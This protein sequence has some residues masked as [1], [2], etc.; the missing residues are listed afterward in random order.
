MKVRLIRRD[1]RR[2]VRVT[3]GRWTKARMR[4]RIVLRDRRRHTVR[5][6]TDYR[7]HGP[8]DD[9]EDP[10]AGPR[11]LG[12][13]IGAVAAPIIAPMGEAVMP[14]GPPVS[15]GAPAAT[16]RARCCCAGSTRLSS[17]RTCLTSES[18][19]LLDAAGRD[20]LFRFGSG[21][22]PGLVLVALSVVEQ[23]YRAVMAVLDGARVS[24]VAAEVGRVAPVAAFVGGALS[25]GRAGRAGG[26]VE[27][28]AVEPEPGVGGGGGAGV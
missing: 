7:P 20:R 2:L 15:R 5:R 23:R 25:R 26:P 9:A 16:S 22:R 24:E 17:L 27:P 4:V 28:A 8:D 12:A 10:R 13:R 19:D 1:G 18:Q 6:F 21:G 14:S 11:P 3:V